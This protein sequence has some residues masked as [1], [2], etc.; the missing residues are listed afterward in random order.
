MRFVA[1][2]GAVAESHREDAAGRGAVAK[3]HR[4]DVAG[5]GADA[6]VFLAVGT[7]EKS[8]R[9]ADAGWSAAKR[10]REAKA[11]KKAGARCLTSRLCATE[12]CCCG[13]NEILAQCCNLSVY[14]Y[15]LLFISL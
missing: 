10:H 6:E 2:R 4:E 11:K 9:E 12:L 3:S 15:V 7:M 1:G 8:H 14:S 5:W 13:E